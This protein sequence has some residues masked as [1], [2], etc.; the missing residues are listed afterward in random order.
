MVACPN[1]DNNTN[2][3]C[4]DNTSKRLS[5]SAL[6]IYY[7]LDYHYMFRFNNEKGKAEGKKE[8]ETD[9]VAAKTAKGRGKA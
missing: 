9:S 4:I 1:T 5:L 8:E 7:I 2:S 6:Y 3:W